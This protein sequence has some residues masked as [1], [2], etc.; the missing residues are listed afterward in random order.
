MGRCGRP[1]PGHFR[2]Q[3]WGVEWGQLQSVAGVLREER[4][5]GTPVSVVE[6]ELEAVLH[7]AQRQEA[8]SAEADGSVYAC[9]ETS[10]HQWRHR[11]HPVRLQRIPAQP[12]SGAA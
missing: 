6:R 10:A 7:A 3:W 11:Q 8:Q 5:P 2:G 9:T 12:V 1:D 4:E